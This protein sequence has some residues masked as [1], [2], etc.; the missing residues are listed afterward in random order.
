MKQ[1]LAKTAAEGGC[2]SGRRGRQAPPVAAPL[3]LHSL[4]QIR[5][6]VKVAQLGSVSRA[7]EHLYRSQPVVTRA[8]AELEE[9]LGVPLFER[10]ASGMLLTGYGGSLLLRAERV[11]E[12]LANIAHL[13]A[14]H[15]GLPEHERGDAE[16][17]YQLNTRRLQIFVRLCET[18]H[19]QTAAYTLGMTQPAVSAALRAV[20]GSIGAMLFERTPRGMT[21]SQLGRELEPCARRVLNELMHL[22]ADLEAYQGRITG[23]LR[24]GALPLGRTRILPEAIVRLTAA[25]PQVQ[26]TTLESPFPML[27]SELRSGE[28]DFVFGALRPE[29]Y[30]SDLRSEPLMDEEIVLL[31]REGHPLLAR[32]RID[33]PALACQRWILPRADS[34]ARHLLERHFLAHGLQ[35]LDAVVETGDLALIRGLLLRSDMVAVVSE[36]QLE[37]ELGI[38]CLR[39]LPIRLPDTARPI[40]LIYRAGALHAPAAAAMMQCLRAMMAENDGPDAP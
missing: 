13:L 40:G 14:R 36:R 9:S 21:P 34:P 1:S 27:V 15:R 5:A 18:Q 2:P 3:E 35:A 32:E 39:P 26:V 19:M 33:Y 11:L 17:L 25:H 4:M 29:E 6:F 31:V 8:I 12:E 20:E 7:A 23:R 10:R 30:A 22:P 24:I 16:P 28:I 37:F 38:G